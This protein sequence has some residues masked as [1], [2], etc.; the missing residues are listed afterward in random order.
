[1]GMQAK[2]ALALRR[3]GRL[4]EA[5]S[6]IA[7]EADKLLGHDAPR[8]EAGALMEEGAIL[9]ESG[10][11]VQARQALERAI[12]I[13]AKNPY[14]GGQLSWAYAYLADLD[15]NAGQ[16]DAAR[17][18]LEGFLRSEHYA[19][20]RT[21]VVLAPALLSA[22]RAAF[23]LGDFAAARTYADDARTIAERA[24]RSADSS[25][26]VGD[27]L[28]MLARIDLATNLAAEAR[29]LIERAV[30]CYSNALGVDAP[31]TAETRGA[32]RGS[33]PMTTIAASCTRSRVAAPSCWLA[34]R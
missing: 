5:R 8:F 16:P 23:A 31:L 7:G 14:G 13:M 30:R 4:Q 34:Q 29:T 11:P 12:S 17:A 20:S 19:Q 2:V 26:D 3:L 24:A 27:T 1:M 25:A 33:P 22:A 10:E 21:K 15:T 32:L 28:M 6:A 18:R 9:A